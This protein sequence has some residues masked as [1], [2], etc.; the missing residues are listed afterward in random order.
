MS[1]IERI[2]G[3]I[4]R[5]LPNAVDL[6]TDGKPCNAKFPNDFGPHEQA[7]YRLVAGVIC[8]ARSP[9]KSPPAHHTGEGR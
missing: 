6:S 2:A 8:R 9:K 3:I 4:A 7:V 5:Y 1:D